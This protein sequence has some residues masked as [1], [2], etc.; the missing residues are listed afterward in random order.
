M[1]PDITGAAIVVYSLLE[2]VDEGL[3]QDVKD[4]DAPSFMYGT[5][6][7]TMYRIYVTHSDNRYANNQKEFR[8]RDVT[9]LWVGRL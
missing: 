7:D 4:S 1:A 2:W 3:V 6:H 8:F 9:K 5:D